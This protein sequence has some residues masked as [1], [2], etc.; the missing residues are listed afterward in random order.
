MINRE[1]EFFD[2]MN[3]AQKDGVILRVGF[4]AE[5][6]SLYTFFPE[7]DDINPVLT[8]AIRRC[9][10]S[11]DIVATSFFGTEEQVLLLHVSHPTRGGLYFNLSTGKRV[12]PDGYG[13]IYKVDVTPKGFRYNR[14]VPLNG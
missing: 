10:P 12:D 7:V 3:L 11:G 13:L 9:T 1:S 4:V 5:T 8:F 6:Q 2:A 14:E